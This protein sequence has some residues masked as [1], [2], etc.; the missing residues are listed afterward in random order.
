MIARQN[1]DIKEFTAEA[2]RTQRKTNYLATEGT[3]DAEKNNYFSNHKGTKKIKDKKVTAALRLTLF[4]QGAET[5]RTQ[6]KTS[7]KGTKT[8]RR[9]KINSKSPPQRRRERREIF[10]YYLQI[11]KS[12]RT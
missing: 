8:L 1:F 6:R 2:Q 7:H 5:Q 4:T 3:E 11:K 9:I 10:N 12:L